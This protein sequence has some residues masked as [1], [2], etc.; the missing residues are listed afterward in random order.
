MRRSI[1]FSVALLFFVSCSSLTLRTPID[2][3]SIREAVFRH[4]LAFWTDVY[5]RYEPASLNEKVFF[6]SIVVDRSDPIFYAP[7]GADGKIIQ[8]STSD[9]SKEFLNRFANHKPQV[10]ARSNAIKDTKGTKDKETGQAGVIFYAGKITRL[11]D[12]DVEVEGGHYENGRSASSETFYLRKEN[13]KW[14]V[15]KT[16][17]HMVS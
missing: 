3:D 2:E 1:L 11:S 8:S 13:N 6:L 12:S 17:T 15:W 4:Q 16:V 9:P 7:I 14:V 10:K 5:A